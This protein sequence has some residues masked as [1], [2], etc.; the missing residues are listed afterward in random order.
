MECFTRNMREPRSGHMIKPQRLGRYLTKNKSFGPTYPRQMSDVSLQVHVGSDWAEDL[1]GRKRTRGKHL[2]THMFLFVDTR[3]VID[4]RSRITTLSF[5][6]RGIQ[7]HCQYWM[8]DIPIDMHSDSSAARSV[9]RRRGIGG[10]LRQSRVA[11]GHLKLDFVAGEQYPADTLTNA[12]ANRK[13]RKW[14]EHVGQRWLQ[15][16]LW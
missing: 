4:W 14:S 3:C 11:L 15:E 9:G 5:E 10:R 6:E 16:L 8:I 12:S 1:L 2:L 7:S 13:I